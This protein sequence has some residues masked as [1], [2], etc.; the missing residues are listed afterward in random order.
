MSEV[1]NLTKMEALIAMEVGG[2]RHFSSVFN[3]RQDQHGAS[4]AWDLHIEGAMGE[5]C[6][7]KVL[8]IYWDG[9]IDVFKRADI[10]SDIQVR[11]RS[12]H[13]Y[14]LIVRDND[15]TDDRYVLVTG[16]CPHYIVRGYIFGLDAHVEEWRKEH[17]GREPAFFVP[18]SALSPLKSEI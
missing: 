5:L 18:Q 11:T 15:S 10:G 14:E 13:D 17:G 12:R 2:M 1:V 4:G 16:K 6:V 3:G 7:A 9:A 8:G